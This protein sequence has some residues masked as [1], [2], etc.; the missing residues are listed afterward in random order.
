[1][2]V[3]FCTKERKN[4]IVFIAA[5]QGGFIVPYVWEIVARKNL[6]IFEGCHFPRFYNWFDWVSW[7]S[8][9]RISIRTHA[10]LILLNW[11]RYHLLHISLTVHIGRS[12]KIA[13]IIRGLSSGKC[14]V[15]LNRRFSRFLNYEHGKKIYR[16]ALK[17]RDW[18]LFVLLL[19]LFYT[20]IL[21]VRENIFLL[22]FLHD[23]FYL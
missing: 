6:T 18:S 15:K 5:R 21:E 1:M 23:E 7:K 12:Q 16:G 22:S 19:L 10:F 13:A 14:F 11:E 17:S 20:C 9:Q 3:N 2:F 8:R 4:K